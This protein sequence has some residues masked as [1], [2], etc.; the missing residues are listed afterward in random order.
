[1]KRT[2]SLIDAIATAEPPQLDFSPRAGILGVPEVTKRVEAWCRE[3]GISGERQ[4]LLLALALLYH[5]HEAA[6]HQLVQEREG[7]QDAD[8][9]HA[10]L[11]RREGDAGNAGYWW[12]AVGAHA[13]FPACAAAAKRHGLAFGDRAFDPRAVV[14]AVMAR[15]DPARLRSY[16]E[17][18]FRLLAAHLAA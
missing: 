13:I 8:I 17:E 18:E 14:K 16:Q 11:H 3:R 7:Q 4:P 6:S 5:D 12:S 1:L 10:I 2:D 9:I 15:Q